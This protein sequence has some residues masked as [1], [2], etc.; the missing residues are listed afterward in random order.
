MPKVK[1][2]LKGHRIRARLF[3]AYGEE[4]ERRGMVKELLSKQFVAE[5]IQ[6]SRFFV[7][8]SDNWEQI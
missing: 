4:Y 2:P 6:G 8:Y 7:F 3:G 5:D 1:K